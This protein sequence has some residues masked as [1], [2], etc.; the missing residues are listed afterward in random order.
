M[1]RERDVISLN[2][3]SKAPSFFASSTGEKRERGAKVLLNAT[4]EMEPGLGKYSA[5]VSTPER[6]CIGGPE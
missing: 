6:K 5:E 1:A 4:R 3:F 2:P